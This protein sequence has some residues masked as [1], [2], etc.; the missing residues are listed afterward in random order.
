MGEM[1]KMTIKADDGN[2]F[3]YFIDPNPYML[4]YS[5]ATCPI[6]EK[7]NSDLKIIKRGD[8]TEKNFTKKELEDLIGKNYDKDGYIYYNGG[9]GINRFF[10]KIKYFA[11]IYH[12]IK[13]QPPPPNF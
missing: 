8:I 6:T 5:I 4:G 10:L 1:D 7:I 13:K 9:S 3:D 2:E 11:K 12:G